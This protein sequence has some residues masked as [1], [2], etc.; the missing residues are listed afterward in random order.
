M[1][2]T[3]GM[4]KDTLSGYSNPACR[5]QRLVR[6]GVYTPVVRGLYESDPHTPPHFLASAIRS[7]S[8]ISFEWALSHYG[9]IPEEVRA[10]TS[11]TC[12]TSRS[13]VYCTPFGTFT[14]RDVPARVFRFGARFNLE[15]GYSWWLATPEKAL[16]DMVY[17]KPA[18]R[19]LGDMEDMVYEDL[20]VYEDTMEG[21]DA[22]IVRELSEMYRS[23][24]VRLLSKMLEVE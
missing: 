11:A 6:D 15:E 13:K 18:V 4:L 7:P 1:M 2:Y 12:A 8:Y 10:V 21:L 17:V 20:R 22:G 23:T 14:Y 19:S 9:M 3:T 24:N 5:L 16:C